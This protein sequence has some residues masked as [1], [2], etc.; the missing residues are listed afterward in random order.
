MGRQSRVGARWPLPPRS[1]APLPPAQA[2][3]E[4]RGRWLGEGDEQGAA[5]QGAA[6]CLE[7]SAGRASAGAAET[8]TSS[9]ALKENSRT[10]DRRF[11]SSHSRSPPPHRHARSSS[12]GTQPIVSLCRARSRSPAYSHQRPQSQQRRPSPSP[13]PRRPSAEAAYL[14]MKQAQAAAAGRVYHVDGRSSRCSSEERGE[15]ARRAEGRQ[16]ASAEQAPVLQDSAAELAGGSGKRQREEGTEGRV[17]CGVRP[18]GKKSRHTPVPA[19]PPS[20]VGPVH[21]SISAPSAAQPADLSAMSRQ[22]LYYKT[23]LC[24][25]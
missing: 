16:A 23:V 20:A 4:S 13:P 21:T 11:L 9:R 1:N 17:S 2:E 22:E 18:Q 7:P 3:V 10:L 15:Q 5:A 8:H 25:R 24:R 12:N 6:G 14:K 19:P